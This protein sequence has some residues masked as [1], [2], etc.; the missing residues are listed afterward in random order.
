MSSK[1]LIRGR[2]FRFN[3]SSY[4]KNCQNSFGDLWF[5]AVTIYLPSSG[6]LENP[7]KL[8]EKSK[9]SSAPGN[10]YHGLPAL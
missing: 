8:Y 10:C 7:L 3:S 2:K 1:G 5:K 9:S 4:F 6:N